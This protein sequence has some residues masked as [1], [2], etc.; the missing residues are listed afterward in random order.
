LLAFLVETLKDSAA[1]RPCRR[2]LDRPYT[3][4]NTVRC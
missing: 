3:C 2:S 1:R 4:L